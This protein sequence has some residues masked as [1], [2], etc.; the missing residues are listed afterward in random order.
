MTCAESRVVCTDSTTG[1]PS[2][3]IAP[4]D[5]TSASTGRPTVA[6]R[7]KISARNPGLVDPPRSSLLPANAAARRD[8]VGS[9]RNYALNGE[10]VVGIVRMLDDYA[11]ERE[12]GDVLLALQPRDERSTAD[13][14]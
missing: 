9:N 13:P 3:G 11:A 5:R 8:K 7:A 6:E 12:G 2:A 14:A 4:I 1:S 10:I